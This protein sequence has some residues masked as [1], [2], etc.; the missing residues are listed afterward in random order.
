MLLAGACVPTG[1]APP[2]DGG[3]A[4]APTFKPSL[5]VMAQ[6]FEDTFDRPD[7][8][9]GTWA[10]LE[11]NAGLAHGSDAGRLTA[12]EVEAGADGGEAGAGREEPEGPLA[13]ALKPEAGPPS[14]LGP[15]WLP[16]KTTAWRIEKGQLCGQGAKNH[17]IW[18]NRV[19]PLN[20]RIEFDAIASNDEG[21]LKAEV[22]GDGKSFARGVSYTDATSYL[23]VLGGWKNSLHVIARLNEHGA[24]RKV[25]PVDKGSDNP[26]ERPVEKGQVYHFKVERTDGKT[27]KFFVDNNEVL[28]WTDPAPLA[29]QGHDHFA[30]NDWEARTCFDNVKVTPLP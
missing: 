11:R 25:L 18:L 5:N 21:D 23:V 8:S 13:M 29:G 4:P 17:G 12:F 26:A 22:W 14:N 20:A 27:V 10:P 9:E 7:A 19:L 16:A 6:P 24:D 2:Y 1:N 30:F 28:K 15:D 3:A